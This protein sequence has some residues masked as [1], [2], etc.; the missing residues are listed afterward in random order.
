[1]S[2]GCAECNVEPVVHLFGQKF[3]GYLFLMKNVDSPKIDFFLL[4]SH[5]D[6]ILYLLGNFLTF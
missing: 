3:L 5:K 1:M 6:T 2:L 4:T